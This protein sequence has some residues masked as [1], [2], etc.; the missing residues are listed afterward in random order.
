LNFPQPI[1]LPD[2]A[3]F[4]D[5]GDNTATF[6]WETG[7]GDSFDSPYTVTFQVFDNQSPPLSDSE[8]VTIEV[9]FGEFG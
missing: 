9:E 7:Y 4:R 5:N 2:G 1:D 8:E 6:T 3:S